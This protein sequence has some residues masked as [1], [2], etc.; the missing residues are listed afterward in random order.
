MRPTYSPES[1]FIERFSRKNHQG[2]RGINTTDAE[3]GASN[4]SARNVFG[5]C[6]SE[7]D[8]CVANLTQV[9]TIVN[10]PIG[11]RNITIDLGFNCHPGYRKSNQTPTHPKKSGPGRIFNF[12]HSR[13]RESY[14][15][16]RCTFEVIFLCPYRHWS[17]GVLKLEEDD[18][19]FGRV[20]DSPVSGEKYIPA[21]LGR[22][23]NFTYRYNNCP[24]WQ[25]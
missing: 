4:F 23:V 18:I 5:K 19:V 17:T 16:Q 7:L 11:S 14:S 6:Y 3:V 21:F 1:R 12:L 9:S 25:R 10:P 2:W 8:L 15:F 13:S 20:A 22:L 24:F